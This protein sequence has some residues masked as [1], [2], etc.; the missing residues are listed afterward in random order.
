MTKE[1]YLK[2]EEN[3]K[4]AGYRRYKRSVTRN[5]MFAQKHIVVVGSPFT[6]LEKRSFKIEEYGTIKRQRLQREIDL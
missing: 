4:Q 2:L 6:G 5:T 3:L 1:Q